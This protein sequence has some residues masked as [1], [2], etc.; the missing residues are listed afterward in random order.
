[1]TMN[2]VAL[3]G[4]F[5]LVVRVRCRDPVEIADFQP[6]PKRLRRST[7]AANAATPQAAGIGVVS[8]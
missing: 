8:D 3:W 6:Q 2:F 1:M 7:F 5:K 4:H